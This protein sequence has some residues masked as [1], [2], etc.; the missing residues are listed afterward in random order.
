MDC[1]QPAWPLTDVLPVTAPGPVP[2]SALTLEDGLTQTALAAL[3]GRELRAGARREHAD[4]LAAEGKTTGRSAAASNYIARE[5]Y[6]QLTRSM[7]PA[8]GPRQR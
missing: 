1:R 7:N 3:A 2:A 5:L 6:R 4:R 8:V